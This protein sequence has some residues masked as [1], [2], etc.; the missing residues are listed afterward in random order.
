MTS[1]KKS[2]RGTDMQNFDGFFDS[3]NR[4]TQAGEYLLNHGFSKEF[5]VKTSQAFMALMLTES[6]IV[7]QQ[8][9]IAWDTLIPCFNEYGQR[10]IVQ[11]IRYKDK[12]MTDKQIIEFAERYNTNRGIFRNVW[13]DRLWISLCTLAAIGYLIDQGEI[14]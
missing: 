1:L 13:L 12:H 14:K 10:M 4:I 2:Q 11:G 6:R 3:A 9:K 8:R 5:V 7:R